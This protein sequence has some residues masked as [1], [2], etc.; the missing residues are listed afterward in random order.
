[1][2]EALILYYNKM[3]YKNKI[4]TI[5]VD[6]EI[7]QIVDNVFTGFSTWHNDTE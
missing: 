4:L 3:I 7:T 5:Y 1:M 2:I 6:H